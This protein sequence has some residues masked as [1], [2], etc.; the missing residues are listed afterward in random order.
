MDVKDKIVTGSLDLFI[1]YGI[2]PVTMDMIAQEL[3]LSKRTIYEH[4]TDKDELL[5]QCLDRSHADWEQYTKTTLENSGNIIE[6]LI[7]IIQYTAQIMS[8]INP[9]FFTDIRKY[10]TEFHKSKIK[11]LDDC[12][13]HQAFEMLE[14]G[15][16][17]GL[18]REDLDPQ[19][20]AEIYAAQLKSM[21]YQD[22]FT[23]DI[24]S[25][26][27][28]IQQMVMS[29]LR[30]IATPKGLEIINKFTL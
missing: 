18:F 30:G 20:F 27:E 10:F 2:K 16:K 1:R 19:L 12:R 24:Y 3:G 5:M 17:E 8:T 25:K 11:A 23:T 21:K 29:L 9:L 13:K 7:K 22:V 4:F 28:I 6:A 14:K 15:K 26:M